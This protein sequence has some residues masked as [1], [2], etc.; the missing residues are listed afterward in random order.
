MKSSIN[1]IKPT[2]KDIKIVKEKYSNDASIITPNEISELQGSLMELNKDEMDDKQRTSGIDL[3]TRLV[4]TEIA[5][6]L[7]LDSL[8]SYKFL[9]LN[10]SPFTLQ[11]KRLAVS[12]AGK[13]RQEIVDIVGGKRD[14]DT[15]RGSL[16]RG[17]SNMFK[18]EQK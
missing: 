15:E 14:T 7:V 11:K 4:N 16:T 8:V 17:I 6:L 12:L 10:I 13:G 1:I 2:L 9:P 18:G 3:R 5:S